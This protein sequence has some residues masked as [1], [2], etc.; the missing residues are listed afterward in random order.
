[1]ANHA[2]VINFSFVNR[3]EDV[4]ELF[5]TLKELKAREN[6][7]VVL[8]IE[9][10][11]GFNCLPEILFRA[12]AVY[13]LGVM[14]ARGDLAIESGWKNIGRVQEEILSLCQAAH[15][16]DIWATQVLESL[17]KRG[18]PSRAEITDAVMS[19]RADCVM[20]NKGP[21]ILEAIQLLDTILKDMEPY[22][23]KNA[24]LSPA[25]ARASL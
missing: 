9:T 7:G 14:I 18:L 11:S 5:D 17:A 20:L 2:D 23:D 15:L 24:P 25:L 13:P 1:M 10:Q 12:M 3:P 4:T 8:K 6:I 16:T 21:Y 19:Q 22:R